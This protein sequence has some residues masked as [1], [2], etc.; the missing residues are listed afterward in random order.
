MMMDVLGWLYKI[1]GEYDWVRCVKAEME[2][3]KLSVLLSAHKLT[4]MRGPSERLHGPPPPL[5]FS[6]ITCNYHTSP[7][8]SL[9]FYTI[10][11]FSVVFILTIR[12]YYD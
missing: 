12:I 2:K 11:Y 7:I 5:P 8:P 3:K 6:Q 1:L 9:L 4:K 10:L